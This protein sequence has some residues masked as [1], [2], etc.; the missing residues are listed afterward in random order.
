MAKKNTF[1][2]SPNKK[3]KHKRHAKSQTSF[4]KGSQNYIKSYRDYTFD[5]ICIDV[6]EVL[7]F[8]KI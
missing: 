4:N 8:E 7:D 5:G 6:I 1:F 3:T 2:F